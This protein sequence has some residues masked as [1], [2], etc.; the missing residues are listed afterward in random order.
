L[1]NGQTHVLVSPYENLP[2]PVVATSWGTQQRF[3]AADDAGIGVFVAAFQKG[4]QT[5]APGATCS[6]GYGEPA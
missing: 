1:T 3:E 4:P 5:P 6:R 2:A